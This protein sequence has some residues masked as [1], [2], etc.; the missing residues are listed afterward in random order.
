MVCY[1]VII[2]G[3]SKYSWGAILKTVINYLA[4]KGGGLLRGEVLIIG[5]VNKQTNKQPKKNF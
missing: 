2:K 4:K 3:L 1:G 5:L